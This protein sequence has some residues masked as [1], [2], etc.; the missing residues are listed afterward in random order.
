MYPYRPSLTQIAGLFL[1]ILF[2]ASALIHLLNGNLL[3]VVLTLP[4]KT[5]FVGPIVLQ[6]CE[7]SG[8][9]PQVLQQ[10]I[11]NKSILVLDDSTISA[12]SFLLF[13]QSYGLGEG[14]TECLTFGS[15]SDYIICCD[16]RRARQMIAKELGNDRLTGSLGL[17]KE[18]VQK[19]ILMVAEAIEGYNTM[20]VKGAFLPNI[21]QNFFR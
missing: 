9:V 20:V 15:I 4:E 17:L 10:A 7:Q 16:D 13:L 8:N 21:D 19:G 6:E 3:D 12:T 1:R 5:W 2:D 18:S 11:D 14:E